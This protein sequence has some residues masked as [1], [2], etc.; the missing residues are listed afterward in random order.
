MELRPSHGQSG[1]NYGPEVRL[2]E[3]GVPVRLA[4][5][6]GCQIEGARLTG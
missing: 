2:G 3:V 1:I 5:F 4:I 6:V